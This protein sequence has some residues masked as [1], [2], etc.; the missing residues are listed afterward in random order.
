MA[1]AKK[2]SGSVSPIQRKR[3]LRQKVWRSIG[4]NVKTGTK[5]G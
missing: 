2:L 1:T 3:A 4:K 5:R